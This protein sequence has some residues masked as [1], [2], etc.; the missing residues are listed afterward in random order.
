MAETA[1]RDDFDAGLGN[2]WVEGRQEVQAAP[3]A[4]TWTAP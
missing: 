4:S 2:R 3:C 1:W